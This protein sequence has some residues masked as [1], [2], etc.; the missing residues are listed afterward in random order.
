MSQSSFI[1]HRSQETYQLTW[2]YATSSSL[3]I[4]SAAGAQKVQAQVKRAE[5]SS[6]LLRMIEVQE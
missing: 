6:P 3:G 4:M 2:I 1:Y 5:L